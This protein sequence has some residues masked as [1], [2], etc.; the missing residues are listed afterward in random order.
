MAPAATLPVSTVGL[1]DKA[2]HSLNP[3]LQKG[4]DPKRTSKHDVLAAVLAEVKAKRD[5]SRRKRWKL[6]KSNGGV[7]IVRNVLEKIVGWI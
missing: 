5:L 3:D 4:L 6:T 1:W 7:V 2:F